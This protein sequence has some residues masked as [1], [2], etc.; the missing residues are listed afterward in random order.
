MCGKRTRLD[1]EIIT[2]DI[3]NIQRVITEKYGQ[4]RAQKLIDKV[5]VMSG[6]FEGNLKHVR[7]KKLC[8]LV[9]AKS[10]VNSD[11]IF[12]DMSTP[13]V[14]DMLDNKEQHVQSVDAEDGKLYF[15]LRN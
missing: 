7:T 15:K 2:E 3:V 4:Q 6:N 9:D 13:G 8:S 12:G 1:A 5:V 10:A 14:R 11:M